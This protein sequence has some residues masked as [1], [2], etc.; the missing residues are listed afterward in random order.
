[1]WQ[2]DKLNLQSHLLIGSA[3]YPSAAVMSAAIVASGAEIVTVSLR[4]QAPAAGGG[5]GFWKIIKEMGL[6]ILPN[7]AGCTTARQAVNTARMA[8]DLFKT[9][10]IKLEVIGDEYNLTPDPFELLAAAKEL[11]ADGF[12]V[13]PYVSSDL[14]VAMRLVEAGCKIV[15]PLAS[16]IGTGRGLVD[17]EALRTLRMRLPETILIVDAGLGRPTHAAQ[18]MELGY[19]GILLNSAVALARDP[20]TMAGAFKLAVEAGRLGCQAGFMATR[21]KASP[22]TP[23]IGQPFWHEAIR[24]V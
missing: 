14:V 10:W 16:P 1:M 13:F 6:H 15:M 5:E 17:S 23:V 21:Q 4:R 9:N 12:L 2:L 22:S 7:T 18:A 3:L 24:H 11:I 8:R 19:D 20:E